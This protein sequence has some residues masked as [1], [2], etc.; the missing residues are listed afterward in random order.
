MAV[1]DS[2]R[3]LC[4]RDLDALR[5]RYRHATGW[6][7]R[8]ID[9]FLWIALNYQDYPQFNAE[10][11]PITPGGQ[12]R[13]EHQ[14]GVQTFGALAYLMTGEA[15]YAEPTRDMLLEL[16][17]A[18]S[19]MDLNDA[20][21]QH[22]WCYS[23]PF[24]R[25]LIAYDW[26]YDS[27]VISDAQHAYI[28]ERV[29]HF[30]WMHPYQRI[31]SRTTNIGEANNQNAAMALALVVGG[32]LFG[33]KRGDDPLARRM[34]ETGL[35]HLVRFVGGL[36][37]GGYS[38]EGSTYM[39]A[40]IGLF[41]PSALDI[42]EQVLGTKLFDKHYPNC[43]PPRKVFEA[44]MHLTMPGGMTLPWDNYGYIMATFIPAAAYYAQRSGDMR[45]LR[46]L[47][48]MEMLQRP[49]RAAW[50]A[51]RTL[52]SMLWFPRNY[53]DAAGPDAWSF[54][55]VEP[56]LGAAVC[57]TNER[58]FAFQMWDRSDTMPLRAHTNPNNLI[59]NYDG[60]PILMDG[61]CV[62][63]AKAEV[64]KQP[65]YSMF[66]VDTGL[67]LDTG[68]GVVGTHNCIFFDDEPHYFTPATSSGELVRTVDHGEA[69]LIEGDA[70]PQYLGY[71]DVQS[72][73][74]QTLLCGDRWLLVRD[75]ITADAQHSVH[76]RWHLRDGQLQCE[77]NLATLRT[78]D[79]IEVHAI[80]PEDAPWQ[81]AHHLGDRTE[82]DRGHNQLES[83]CHELTWMKRGK[84]VEV[85][86]LFAFRRHR[87]LWHD[88]GRGWQCRIVDTPEQAQQLVQAETFEAEPCDMD[89]QGWFMDT[90]RDQPGVGVWARELHID[91]LPGEAVWLQL[92]RIVQPVE[93]HINDKVYHTLTDLHRAIIPP[94]I[95]ID[96]ALQPGTNRI[97]IVCASTLEWTLHGSIGLWVDDAEPAPIRFN[98]TATDAYE[99]QYLGET[100]RV[101]WSDDQCTLQTATG[102]TLNM[103]EG[104][105]LP[106]SAE[107]Q[108][109]SNLDELVHMYLSK[110]STDRI[111]SPSDELLTQWAEHIEHGSW[112]QALRAMELATGTQD[113]AVVEATLRRIQHEMEHHPTPPKRPDDD[114]IW[115]RL[116]AAGA[117]LLGAA[118][119]AP[120]VP[121]LRQLLDPENMYP[122]TSAAVT[123][124]DQIGTDEAI[125][126]IEALPKNLEHNTG[127]RA[128]AALEKRQSA[129][130]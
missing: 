24:A 38:F 115:Y 27:G 129:Q 83:A 12:V 59:A 73:R 49:E 79:G 17:D 108:P 45:P 14:P 47:V 3:F 20:V 9:H 19:A 97:R 34:I 53:D 130:V 71:Q 121:M 33:C 69:C 96:E 114:P 2:N 61:K 124:L 127:I 95:R 89:G 22:C 117:Y 48:E 87:T 74:R 90:T 23:A 57:S 67:W 62:E 30:L 126:A 86:T 4:V 43:A 64:F 36:A 101:T 118:G 28:R 15:R 105:T 54:N 18:Q 51:D 16:M 10:N 84:D 85:F 5:E 7:R 104:P 99:I 75:R 116:K 68:Q 76:G 109:A 46:T 29:M 72:V 44:L 119:H 25:F 91:D 39:G 112:Q 113:P 123:A 42:V 103:L 106:M 77:G 128:T 11:L 8:W 88:L 110:L 35:P 81:C 66:K 111:D 50:G 6:Q 52:W 58:L 37:P 98:R 92:A 63:V 107:P 55:H 41:Y 125:A 1:E 21:Q 78:D 60:L 82:R 56:S 80:S 120:A 94:A 65:Q 93:I 31:K 102:E 32:Y 26:I 70:T 122:V 13:V 100:E 40:V